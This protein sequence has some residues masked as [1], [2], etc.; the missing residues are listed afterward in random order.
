[1]LHLELHKL[2]F[3]ARLFISDQEAVCI[4]DTDPSHKTSFRYIT[5][6]HNRQYYKYAIRN[7]IS[8]Y[9]DQHTGYYT[10]FFRI[11]RYEG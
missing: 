3:A 10:G 11:D 5:K 6:Y 9:P 4:H 7:T 2:H 8:A 1:M